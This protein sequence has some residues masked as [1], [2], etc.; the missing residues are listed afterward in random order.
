MRFFGKNLGVKAFMIRWLR[1]DGVVMLLFALA[2]VVM[3]YP[4][5][6]HLGGDWVTTIPESG[7]DVFMKLWDIWWLGQIAS[8]NQSPLFTSLIFYPTGLDMSFH[9]ISWT[10]SSLAWL[11]IP[12]TGSLLTAYKITILTGVFAAAYAAYLLILELTHNRPAA[13]LGGAIYSFA[14]YHI[15]HSDSHPDHTHL[16][17]I[18]IAALLLI[19]AVRDR[20]RVAALGA[21]LAVGFAA[22]TSVYILDFAILTLAPLFLLLALEHKSWKHFQF[23]QIAVVF[24][25]TTFLIVGIRFLPILAN[26]NNFGSTLD[27]LS[28]DQHQ[29]D[30]L[31]LFLPSSFHEVFESTLANIAAKFPKQGLPPYLGIVPILLT[32]SALTWKA[33]RREVWFWFCVGFF[34]ILLSLGPVLRFNGAL[35]ENVPMLWNLVDWFPLISA[36]RPNF[37]H[38]ALLLPLAVC[39]AYGFERWLNIVEDKRLIQ[40]TLI[41]IVSTLLLFEYWNGY[42]P[43]MNEPIHPFYKQIAE[44][45][46]DFAIIQLPMSRYY[47]KRYLYDQT[48][49]GKPILEGATARTPERVYG[50]IAQNKL[51]D[52]WKLLAEVDCNAISAEEMQ[53]AVDQLVVD[54]FRYVIVHSQPPEELYASYFEVEPVYSGDGITAYNLLD[55]QAFPPCSGR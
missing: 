35:F 50:Y 53:V 12:I 7:V 55:M 19:K 15:A 18:P 36:V 42:F 29:A 34:F 3:T 5:I 20:S 1:R 54:G 52:Q 11:F 39:S 38:S 10:V 44:E 47:S 28:H 49:H 2:T 21:A 24:G 32:L 4:L 26:I 31:S 45:D 22:F 17:V 41:V 46:G 14:P 16:A 25:I 43:I 9:S 40:V 13:W 30:L 33:K 37:F 23:W 48:V 6:L 8:G 27:W 51:L